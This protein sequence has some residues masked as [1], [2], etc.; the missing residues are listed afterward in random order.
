ML[1]TEAACAS[2]TNNQWTRCGT[3]K[4]KEFASTPVSVASDVPSLS[5]IASLP[6]WVISK[7]AK[8]R[9]APSLGHQY[10]IEVSN[11]AGSTRNV[12]RHKPKLIFPVAPVKV[13]SRSP[14]N[15]YRPFTAK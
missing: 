4:V 10:L 14:A 11:C 7:L 8:A 15:K 13:L 1:W 2:V 3:S 6:A 9:P 12:T 5:L